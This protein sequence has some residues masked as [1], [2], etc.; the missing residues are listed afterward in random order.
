MVFGGSWGSTLS[1]SYAQTHPKRTT[2]LILRGIFTLQKE[3]IDW[4]YQEGASWLFPDAWEDYLK[5]IPE[6]ERDDMVSAY[7]KRLTSDSETE[8]LEA[9]RAWSVWEGTTVSLLPSPEREAAF[10][11]D[12]FAT[13]FA[14]IEL[15]LFYQQW[16]L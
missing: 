12:Q 5:P 4:F 7:Y 6:A 15:P 3:E 16:L 2:E 9:A 11:N 10:S 13:A 1:L 8:R 14:R